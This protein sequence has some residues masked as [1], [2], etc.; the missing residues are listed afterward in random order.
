ME[1]YY[2]WLECIK[3]LGP[4]GWHLLLEEIGNPYEIYRSRDFL[5]PQGKITEHCIRLIKEGAEQALEKAKIILDGCREQGIHI[6]KY[7]DPEFAEN[8][9]NNMEFPVLFYYKGKIKENWTHGT[10]IV[11]GR[12]CSQEGKE[13][14]VRT[15]VQMVGDNRPVISGMAKG[16]DS[17]AHTAAINNGGYTIAVLGFGIDQ[18]YPIEHRKL[19]EVIAEKGLLI[20]EYPPGTKPSKFS[21]PR[22]NRII[23]GL[24]DIIYVIDTGKNSGTASTVKAGKRYGK[25]IR[26]IDVPVKGEER[27][28][29]DYQ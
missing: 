14:S 1:L 7:E 25:I 11:G 19:K 15:A 18:C 2:I 28:K 27:K 21:F 9:K 10:G 26:K 13:C 4:L 8:I 29:D 22:R 6:V 16:I 20:S 17:Y 24:S 12:R 3:G 5:I 23:A